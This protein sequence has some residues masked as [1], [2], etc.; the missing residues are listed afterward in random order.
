MKMKQL[1][2]R[3]ALL[4]SCIS[5]LTSFAML[6]SCTYAWFTDTA[7]SGANRIEAGK[8]RVEAYHQTWQGTKPTPEVDESDKIEGKTDL[9]KSALNNDNSGT[10]NNG[11][12]YKLWE[13]G[14][15]AVETFTI[16]NEGEL[17]LKYQFN[18]VAA[19]LNQ[20]T[21]SG[22]SSKSYDL[23]DVIKVAIVSGDDQSN[24]TS[25]TD[26]ELLP[27]TAWKSW[28]DF[29]SGA[30]KTGNLL[31]NN[32]ESFIVAMWWPSTPNDNYYNLYARDLGKPNFTYYNCLTS[33][34]LI[35]DV[36]TVVTAT[37]NTVEADSFGT[38][39]DAIATWGSGNASVTITSSNND[40]ALY[41]RSETN[42]NVTASIPVAVVSTDAPDTVLKYS[43][44]YETTSD[45][46]FKSFTPNDGDVTTLTLKVDLDDQT[47]TSATY[48]ISLNAVTVNK[49][50]STQTEIQ[51]IKKLN[52]IVAVSMIIPK[53]LQNVTVKHSG[54]AMTEAT[55]SAD[56]GR[57]QYYAYDSSSGALTIW[58][59]SFSPFQISWVLDTVF[60]PYL[61]IGEPEIETVGNVTGVDII[62]G[63]G[64]GDYNYIDVTKDGI[65]GLAV[66][67]GVSNLN[68]MIHGA[69]YVP[70]IGESIADGSK[71]LLQ[72][73]R[74]YK[75]MEGQE[76]AYATLKDG[77]YQNWHGDFVMKFNKAINAFPTE[78]N[79]N[80][81]NTI[82]LVGEYG[83]WG[84]VKIPC[85]TALNANKEYRML[86]DFTNNTISINFQ[87]LCTKVKEFNCGAIYLNSHYDPSDPLIMTIEFRMYPTD[88]AEETETNTANQETGKYI[89]VDTFTYTFQ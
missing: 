86:K 25:R 74:Q 42:E 17:A 5:L 61:Q 49:T 84:W 21:W 9:F 69:T 43:D 53:G 14:A 37:Q 26:F 31:P 6:L 36:K 28:T 72:N 67:L 76:D 41:I 22:D 2:T 8:F 66:R 1:K 87:E 4:V 64:I 59:S 77:K 56:R 7:T 38:D 79:G 30:T 34:R 70:G 88:P 52:K 12:E 65:D 58:T 20:V 63:A 71:L 35:I 33:D 68:S 15:M 40:K 3:H 54:T 45:S 46:G 32:S 85:P 89:V 24:Y 47:E 80:L 81:D 44:N 82:I 18:L 78:E 55:T 83:T 60:A 23:R 13:P 10:G 11:T 39:Y 48:D 62:K 29:V 57:D 51:D 75:V 27:Q 50:T 16:K 19:A 73:A